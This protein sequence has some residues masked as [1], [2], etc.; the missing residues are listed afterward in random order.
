MSGATQLSV[1][2]AYDAVADAAY[3]SVGPGD[4]ETTVEVAPGLLVDD[5]AS[6]R[7][8]G[9]EVLGVNRRVGIGDRASY[10][11]GLIE[12]VLSGAHRA[13]G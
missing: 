2:P 7:P 13:A 10:L 1:E 6:G 8:V 5:D 11:R 4:V 9:I 12:G 3:A